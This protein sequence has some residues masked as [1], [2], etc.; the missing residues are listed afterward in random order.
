MASEE[1]I[2]TAQKALKEERLFRCLTCD[3]ILERVVAE[4]GL[5]PGG[6]HYQLALSTNEYKKLAS[7]KMYS[8]PH[9]GKS[10]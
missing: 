1:V 7:D 10:I 2:G 9:S 6:A 8:F 4:E 3:A 5:R